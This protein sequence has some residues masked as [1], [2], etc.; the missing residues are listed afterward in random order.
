MLKMFTPWKLGSVEIPNRLMRSATWEGMADSRGRAEPRLATLLGNLAKGGVG[1]VVTGYAYVLPE[2]QGLPAQTGIHNDTCVEPLARV[3]QAIHRGGAKA[4][5]QLAHAGG[6]TKSE[7]IGR[8]PV[9]PTARFNQATGEEV[10]ELPADQIPEIIAAFGAGALRVKQAGFDAVQ[11][12]SA[13]GY[14]LNQ[15]L[16]P[17]TNQRKDQ[18]G[19]SAENRLRFVMEAYQAVRNAVGDGFPVYIKLNLDDGLDDG[20]KPAEALDVAKA[21]AAA[22]MDSIEASGGIAGG[23]KPHKNGPGRV[24]KGPEQE[25]YFLENALALKKL[26]DCPVISVGG[27]RSPDRIE[28]ALESLDAVA[29]S[30]PFIREPGLARRWEQGDLRTATCISCGQCLI[31]GTKGGIACG[32]DLKK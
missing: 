11:L 23:G 8:K 12:H 32:Q 3:A 22:G 9:G 28:Q 25:G 2:G 18:Y 30:R 5:V 15:F 26:V 14:L 20:L 24:V 13:H 1:L 7:L 19:G 16:S 27:W 17:N 31:L 10:E 21:L 29:I 6:H 4:V